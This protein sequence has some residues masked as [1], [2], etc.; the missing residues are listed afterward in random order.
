M[1]LVSFLGS[2]LDSNSKIILYAIDLKS[3]TSYIEAVTGIKTNESVINF[4]SDI[5]KEKIYLRYDYITNYRDSSNNNFNIVD[6]TFFIKNNFNELTGMLCVNTDY[7]QHERISNKILQLTTMN[8]LNKNC[9]KEYIL[10][11]PSSENLELDKEIDV[12]NILPLN[13]EKLIIESIEPEFLKKSSSLNQKSKIKIIK[14]LQEKG[15][16]RIKGAVFQ[17][18]KVL[19]ISEPSIYRYLKIINKN[20]NIT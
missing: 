16:F 13:I 11:T 9:P 10:T 3:K 18:A 6:S 14:N 8:L 2:I 12:V 15:I 7:S 19:L 17:V 20:M 4:D 1:T 5:F